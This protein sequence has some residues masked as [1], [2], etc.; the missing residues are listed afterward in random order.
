M[1]FKPSDLKNTLQKSDIYKLGKYCSD[2]AL[3][4]E[5]NR[6]TSVYIEML[7]IWQSKIN[8]ISRKTSN[9]EILARHILDGA[10]IA[11]YI[12]KQA[13]ILDLGAG[14]GFIGIM[15]AILGFQEI[16]LVDINRKKATF[17]Q[18]VIGELGMQN[19]VKVKAKDIETIAYDAEYIVSRA[20]GSIGKI[21]QCTEHIRHQH[22]KLVLHKSA[23][24]IDPEVT[25]A[26][27]IWSFDLHSHENECSLD[28]KLIV[29]EN[30]SLLQTAM[31]Q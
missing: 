10:Q 25:H 11:S 15:L 7:K 27:N 31:R 4:E 1:S 20:F 22:C 30:V 23:Q 17:L 13:K 2:N 21:L 16:L 18:A 19:Q 28:G 6:K 9:S 26:K 5:V 12:P 14:A 29:I 24:Q 8:L 3:L